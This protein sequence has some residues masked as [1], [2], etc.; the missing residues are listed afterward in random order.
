LL[1]GAAL[2]HTAEAGL[3]AES[4]EVLTH[5]LG[6]PV[7]LSGFDHGWDDDPEAF[8]D[9]SVQFVTPSA[10]ALRLG[11]RG[12]RPLSVQTFEGQAQDAHTAFAAELDTLTDGQDEQVEVYSEHYSLFNGVFL[13]APAN[14]I[15]QIADLPGVFAV[16][17]SVRYYAIGQTE[18]VTGSALGAGDYMKESLALLQM[19]YIHNTLGITGRGVQIAVLDTG[20]DFNHPQLVRFQ[21]PATGRI[22]GQN[23]TTSTKTVNPNDIMDRNGHGTHVTGTVAAIAPNA[24]LWHYKV[25]GDNGA[26]YNN[27]ILSGMEQAHTDGMD[28]ISLSLGALIPNPLDPMCMAANLAVLDGLV[29][30]IAAGNDGLDGLDIPGSASLPITVANGTAGGQG[31]AYYGDTIADSS[32]RGPVAD[33]YHIK[34]D[35]TAPG[36]AIVSLLPL[37][38]LN[39]KTN[40]ME[41]TS[42]YASM[43]GTSMATPHVAGIAVLMLEAFPS[44][45]PIEVKARL[46]NTA[47][48]LAN[49]NGGTVFDVG[50]GFV[51][52][53]TALTDEAFATVQH[54]I[55]W[56]N[57]N[58][59]IWRMETMASL[60]FGGVWW[61]A[62]SSALPITINNPGAGTWV[63]TVQWNGNSTGVRLEVVAGSAGT[64]TAKMVFDPEVKDGLYGGNLLLTNG[65]Q[66]I[67]IPFAAYRK[68]PFVDVQPGDWFYNAV[69]FANSNDLMRGVSSTKF[70]PKGTVTR[71]MVATILYRAIGEPSV[72]AGVRFTDVPAGQWY[73]NA[74]NFMAY[75]GIVKGVGNNRFAPMDNV[76][77]EQFATMLYRLYE[78]TNADMTVP[79]GTTLT[80]FSDY[81]KVS[82]W[83]ETAL[84][85]TNYTGLITG[86]DRGTLNPQGN[87][88]RAEAATILYRMFVG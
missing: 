21:D 9:V 18:V 17:P 43:T 56:L 88:T 55:P 25:L 58:T 30:T 87:T 66:T 20:V 67:T 4:I 13:R 10:V 45:A 3:P 47:R 28:V 85:W 69:Y 62:E 57:G 27:W 26:G 75:I 71:A 22:R 72:P 16:T 34:P 77:R 79:A 64:F 6:Q 19:D 41:P 68:A 15:A 51:V 65:A 53:R 11:Y 83:A 86:T 14:M 7:G 36:T 31:E 76:T 46:M 32:S 84:L 40:K 74:V 60:S 42:G 54:N 38:V 61:S 5:T 44:A 24:E 49:I 78:A 37:E 29:V 80:G 39:P 70:A 23:F 50:A 82:T 81:T 52:P 73:T 35:I 1:P 33:T 59:P 12:I 63:P 2:A 48:P 8:V